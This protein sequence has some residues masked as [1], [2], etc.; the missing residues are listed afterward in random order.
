MANLPFNLFD[1]L[2][3]V[4]M[5]GGIV[6][7]RRHGMSREVLSMSK[8]LILV[9]FCALLYRPLGDLMAGAGL[10]DLLTC[11]LFTYL[12][13]ALLVF[14]AFSILERRLAP[15]VEGSDIFGRS[16][17]FLGMGT[18][19]LRFVS[20]LL[21]GLALLNARQFSPAELRDIETYQQETY[22]SDIFPGLHSLQVAVFEHSF[23]GPFIKEELAF[24]LIKPTT[25]NDRGM[26][27]EARSRQ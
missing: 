27:A 25:A 5:V 7:G 4:I 11:Y 21:F 15:K 23:T 19:V 8:W 18:G 3:A 12:G 10:F 26:V 6:H 13:V 16:E 9:L 17:Y 24:L 14:L 1:I 20:I 2:L 22:G